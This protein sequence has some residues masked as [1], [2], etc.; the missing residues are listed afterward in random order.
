LTVTG[1]PFVFTWFIESGTDGF[2]V[3]KGG[4]ISIS[5]ENFLADT[6]FIS[7]GNYFS[8]FNSGEGAGTAGDVS[9]S[10]S[11][12]IDLTFSEINTDSFDFFFETGGNAGS[13]T[14]AAPE[15]T[16]NQ[17]G[18]STAGWAQGGNVTINSD[19]VELSE[20]NI[21]TQTRTK[22]GGAVTISG[23]VLELVGSNIVS[24]TNENAD[25]GDITI[26]ATERLALLNL[27]GF[28]DVPS[29]ILSNSFANDENGI[30]GTPGD[31]LIAT[32]ILE[33]SGGSRINTTSGSSGNGGNVLLNTQNIS[34]SGQTREL[35]QEDLINFGEFQ[36]TG[37]FTRSIGG[38]CLGPCGDAGN[39]T[40]STDSIVMNDGAQINSGTSSDGRGGNITLNATVDISIAGILD[41]GTPGGVFTQTIGTE[42]ESGAGGRIALTAGQNFTQSAGATLSASSDGPGNAGDIHV[43]AANTI[44]LDG[45]S[46]TTEAAQASG[47]NI[48]LTAQDLIRL[49]NTTISSS[50]Q[51]DATTTGG[52]ISLDP[53]FIILQNSQILA[54][55]VQGQGGNISLI[56]NNAVLVDPLS[57]L[58]ASS[59]LG[60]SGSVDIQAPIQNLSGTLAPLPEDTAPVTALYGE[61]CAAGSGGHFS[62]FVDSKADSLSP[63]PGAFLAS[64]L[65]NLAAP[66]HAAAERSA[67]Q[68]SPVILTASIAP[69]VLGHAGDPATACP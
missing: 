36:P 39:V 5:A 17:S 34:M 57:V 35:F 68:K 30:L 1:D 63:T 7:T 24:T 64:P 59:A 60:V 43:T 20:S 15:V 3:G 28:A 62:T 23:R 67:G 31:I 48:K 53:D 18:I 9:I 6:T 26:T 56:A 50:V 40:I 32:P 46:I 61:R 4:D 47:G 10:A 54:K 22:P 55:A 49:N 37:V 25:A 33:M 8:F 69:L 66:A 27:G 42:P 44:L 14:L 52:N 41:D 45:A 16:F 21:V 58:D 2:D 29:G 13:V 38:S 19:T 11:E 12:K 65:L 51:G